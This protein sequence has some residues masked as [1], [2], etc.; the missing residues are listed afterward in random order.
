MHNL[1]TGGNV[2]DRKWFTGSKVGGHYDYPQGVYSVYV[3]S[4]LNKMKDNY[5][6]GGADYTGKTV[7]AV[8]KVTIAASSVKLA[9]NKQSVVRGNGFTVTLTGQPYTTYYFG[10]KGTSSIESGSSEIPP[11]ITMYQE[12]V[13]NLTTGQQ[14]HA[15]VETD[16]SGTRTVAFTTSNSTK[17]RKYTIRAESLDFKKYDEI[18]VNVAEGSVTLMAKGDQIYYLGEEIKFSGT[19]SETNTAYLFITGPNLNSNGA[20]IEDPSLSVTNGDESTFKMIDVDSDDAFTYDWATA[21]VDLDAGTYT[22]YAISQPHDKGHLSDTAYATTSITVKKPYVSAKIPQ[23]TVAKG[24]KI[25]IE[26]I[27]SGQ[28]ANVQIWIL[29][30]NF[31][32]IATQSVD[33]DDTYKYEMPEGETTDMASGQY[34]LIVQHPMQNGQFDIV[35]E[36]RNGVENAVVRNLQLGD[37]GM[38]IFTLEGSGSLQGSDAAEALVQAINDPNI[39]DTYTKLN[40]MLTESVIAIDPISDKNIGDKFTLTG[41]TNLAVDDE[42]MIE[43]Y[44]SSFGPTVKTKSGEFSG[45]TAT[46]KV[47]KG[48]VNDGLNMFTLDIDSSSF[49][50]DEYLVLAQGVVQEATGTALF[51]VK[52]GTTLPTVTVTAAPALTPIAPITVPPTVPTVMPTA[53]P[54]TTKSPGFGAIYALVGLIGIGFVI[55]RREE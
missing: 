6:S 32:K 27:A 19:N 45:T 21:M 3:E 36:S 35:A 20:R 17:E 2:I 54:T 15:K 49:K 46:V 34:F 16:G 23:N 4:D 52:D 51:N 1:I 18:I 26:G 53:I 7:S 13:S 12:G 44:S 22:V 10:L 39:D 38:D 30:K 8:Y 25:T 14:Y 28:P 47:Q 33:N 37:S 11:V 41:R 48:S 55:V 42:V 5:R 43:I 40:F 50:A 29:G 24:D 9:A 31:V